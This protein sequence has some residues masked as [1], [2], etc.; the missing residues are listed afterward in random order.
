MAYDNN[1]NSE[2]RIESVFSK[3]IRAGKRRTYFFDVRETRGSDYFLTITESRKRFD[4]NGYDRHKIFIYKEDF[5]KFIKA[6]G[7][8]IDHVKTELMPDFDFDAFNHE[9]EMEGSEENVEASTAT[10]PTTEAPAEKPLHVDV[11]P[12]PTE[13]TTDTNDNLS[14][15]EVDK[16]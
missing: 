3:R 14:S 5:N 11:K 12:T 10:Q 13:N 2:K 1:D 9:Y 8:T 16:W 4:D 15:E 6:L 7:E